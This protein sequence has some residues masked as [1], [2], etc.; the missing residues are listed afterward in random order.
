MLPK[1]QWKKPSSLECEPGDQHHTT[2][3]L[4]EK[5]IMAGRPSRPIPLWHSSKPLATASVAADGSTCATGPGHRRPRC[6]V[7]TWKPAVD[8]VRRRRSSSASCA[9]DSATVSKNATDPMRK[10]NKLK[11][12]TKRGE[13]EMRLLVDASR[14]QSN[15]T[16]E[17]RGGA[18][19]RAHP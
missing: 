5:G 10:V 9:S 14:R 16:Q 2:T 11:Y 4:H 13:V 18:N 8:V 17:T 7:T 3:P 15:T 1:K 12:I 6:S 19:M